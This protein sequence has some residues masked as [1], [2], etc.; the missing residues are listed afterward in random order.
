MTQQINLYLPEFRRK[1]DHLTFDNMVLGVLGLTLVLI[2]LTAVEFWDSYKLGGE[3]EQRRQALASVTAD[4]EQ[5]IC[6]FGAQ[7]EDPALSRRADELETEVNSK[8]T[9]ER[10]L[11]GRNIGSTAGFSEYL[12]DLSRY[13]L[14]GLR[15]TGVTL[16]NGGKNVQLEGEVLSPYLVPQY[17]QSLRQGQS[18]AGKEFETIRIVD[19][20]GTDDGRQIKQFRVATAN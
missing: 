4:T 5:L 11:S 1:K 2:V 18:F 12:S 20:S 16:S 7:S 10:F 13:H 8:H 14:G 6:D 9:L 19:I 3:L 17:F 15:L